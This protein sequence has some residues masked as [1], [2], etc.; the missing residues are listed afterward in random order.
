MLALCD[1]SF[2][3]LRVFFCFRTLLELATGPG[4]ACNFVAL[5]NEIQGIPHGGKN[6]LLRAM[7]G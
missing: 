2:L 6:L 7:F 5:S 3:C 1:N 4:H